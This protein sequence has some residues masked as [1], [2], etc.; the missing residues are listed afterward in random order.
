MGWPGRIENEVPFRQVP[1]PIGRPLIL[2][3]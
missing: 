1:D 3:A 2:K